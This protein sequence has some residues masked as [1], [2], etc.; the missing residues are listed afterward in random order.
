MVEDERF[1]DDGKPP[2]MAEI[3]GR[4]SLCAVNPEATDTD[5]P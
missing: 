4:G 1:P 2:L 5:P 3:I